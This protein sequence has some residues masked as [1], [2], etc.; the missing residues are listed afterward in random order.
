MQDIGWDGTCET[1][2]YSPKMIISKHTKY[3]RFNWCTVPRKSQ[4]SENIVTII[5]F[6]INILKLAKQFTSFL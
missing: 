4:V 2:I 3:I 5:S 6:Q 1:S